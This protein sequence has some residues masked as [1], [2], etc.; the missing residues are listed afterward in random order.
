M[1]R[2]V[3]LPLSMASIGFTS[4]AVEF[5]DPIDGQL[6][7]GEYLAEN[8]YGFLPVP[9]MITEPAVGYGGGFTGIFLHESD[10]QREKRKQLAA[11]S[12]DGGAQLL[13]PAIT[14]VGGFATENGTWMGF[15]GHRRSW[16]QDT[17][18]Y[19]GGLGY[20]EVN[21]TFYNQNTTPILEDLGLGQG[22]ELG[23]KGGGGI[24]R[25]QFRLDDTPLFVGISQ[26]YF[27][28]KLSINS[29]PKAND[30]LSKI[31]NPSPT[32]SGLGIYLEYDTKNSFLS[33]TQ[34]YNYTLE[35]MWHS[36]TLGSDYTYQTFDLEGVNYWEINSDWN[37]ALRGQYKSLSSDNRFLPP[38]YYPDIQ[39]RGIARNRYQGDHTLALES[40]LAYQWTPRWSSNVFGGLGYATNTSDALLKDDSRYAYGLGFRY[41]IAR[42]YGLI[43]G[44]DVAFSEEDSAL[45]FQVGA[46]L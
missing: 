33:P 24:Q 25:L 22:I 4:H 23:F 2:Q 13:T 40:Q 1:L 17:I 41:L 35:Y 6:D 36:D 26:K 7:M 30:I 42:R 3:L 14:A 27:A 20:G 18:R 39:L 28:P 46:G 8:A 11:Q 31:A 32:S 19:L 9:I 38:Q 16:K 34:G 44:I 12:L 43:A 37:F 29:H 21:M 15:I 5:F 45:Y 10:E